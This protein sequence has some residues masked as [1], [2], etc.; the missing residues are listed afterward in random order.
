MLDFDEM[1]RFRVES[2]NHFIYRNIGVYDAPRWEW[3][4]S[5]RNVKLAAETFTREDGTPAI[6]LSVSFRPDSTEEEDCGVIVRTAYQRTRIMDL[7]IL[8]APILSMDKKAK[9]F[10]AHMTISQIKDGMAHLSVV[11]KSQGQPARMF[12]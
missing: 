3:M 9:G 4:K 8:D 10:R 5:W 11:A 1:V 2:E 7:L 6:I 12:Y